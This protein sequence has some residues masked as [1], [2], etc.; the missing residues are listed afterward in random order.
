LNRFAGGDYMTI[1]EMDC[2]EKMLTRFIEKSVKGVK[3]DYFRKM[4][5]IYTTETSVE[6]ISMAEEFRMSQSRTACSG[7]CATCL[8]A[9][10]CAAMDELTERQAFIIN[11]LFTEKN[12]EDE[13]AALLGISQQAVSYHKTEAIK[14]LRKI[15]TTKNKGGG[16]S[17]DMPPA[18]YRG[19]IN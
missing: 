19:G 15:L 11:K 5:R 12:T 4:W 8:K 1:E 9:S 17:S 10:I 18:I 14:K 3:K 13:I 6:N 16:L 2:V 7:S